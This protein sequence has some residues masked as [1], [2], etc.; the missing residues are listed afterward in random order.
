MNCPKCR[1]PMV[2]LEL[3]NVEIDYCLAC[4]GVWLDSG[5]LE[6][7][8]G[9]TYPPKLIPE[10]HC[11]ERK[12]KCPKCARKMAKVRFGK[13]DGILIDS[14]TENHGLWFDGGEL[15]ELLQEEKHD[16]RIFGLLGGIF[17]KEPKKEGE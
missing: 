12:I 5:E 7:L 13:P 9:D 3:D 14:C 17:S 1:K 11:A 4:K 6:L 8:L 10:T 16:N 2:V 15:E